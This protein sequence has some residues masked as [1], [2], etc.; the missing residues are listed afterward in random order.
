MHK[1]QTRADR[2]MRSC[3]SQFRAAEDSGKKYIEGY[4]SVFGDVYE[5]FPGGTESVDAGAFDG[6]LDG[7]IRALINHESRMVLGRTTAGTLEL[8]TDSHGLWG[9]IEINEN[10]VDAMNLY[11]RVQRGDVDQCSFGFEILDERTEIDEA[12]GAVHWTILRVKLWEVSV[13]TF[14]AYEQT[15]VKARMDE[16]DQIKSRRADAWRERMKERINKWH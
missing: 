7:D 8:K 15:S 6:A 2:Q 5:L 9:R 10:D 14:P 12:T 13:V 1:M 11:A 3:P 16:Y 4:F